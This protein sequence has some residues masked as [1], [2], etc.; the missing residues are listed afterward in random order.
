MSKGIWKPNHFVSEKNTSQIFFHRPYITMGRMRRPGIL[1]WFWNSLPLRTSLALFSVVKY[2]CQT[3]Q[4][5][6]FL[7]VVTSKF[8][9]TCLLQREVINRLVIYTNCENTYVTYKYIY[10]HVIDNVTLDK[11]TKI[12]S[13]KSDIKKNIHLY[14]QTRIEKSIFYI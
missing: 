7:P 12:K 3:R 11:F 5:W 9:M 8:F 6:R 4:E 1:S 13:Y 14:Q 2:E 10:F